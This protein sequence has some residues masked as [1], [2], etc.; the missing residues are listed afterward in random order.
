M[1]FVS[2]PSFRAMSDPFINVTFQYRLCS[3]FK[4]IKMCAFSAVCVGR[5]HTRKMEK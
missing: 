1:R 2:G 3:S 5:G 4:L